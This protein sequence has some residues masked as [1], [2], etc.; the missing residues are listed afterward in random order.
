MVVVLPTPPFWLHIEIT[1][2]WVGPLTGRRVG[3]LGHRSPGRAEHRGD[4]PPPPA[5]RAVSTACLGTGA[6]ASGGANGSGG[7]TG[8]AASSDTGAAGTGVCGGIAGAVVP[9]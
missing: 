9:W 4:R 3:E 7:L 2:A 1:R 8:A 5:P 6:S